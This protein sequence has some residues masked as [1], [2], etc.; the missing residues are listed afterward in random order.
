MCKTSEKVVQ[1]LLNHVGLTNSG[2][3]T[4][5]REH[6]STVNNQ[7]FIQNSFAPDPQLKLMRFDLLIMTLCTVSTAPI[8]TT[9]LYRKA[10][11]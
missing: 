3:C 2:K 9:N 8:T 7:L 11:A 5:N 1:F 10:Q 6:S 4:F